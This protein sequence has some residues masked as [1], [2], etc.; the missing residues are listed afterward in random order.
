[1]LDE[2]KKAV[3][4]AIVDDYVETAEP[5]GSKSLVNKHGFTWSSATI[6]NE[7]AELEHMGYLESPHTSA[8]R[9]PSDMGYRA[10][11]DE[12]LEIEELEKAEQD[13]V[14]T[15]L[16]EDIDEIP[17][18]IRKAAVVLAGQ[19]Q[20]ASLVLAPRYGSS[21][22]QQIRILMIEPGCALVI[23]VLSA[24][25][26]KDRVVRI[27]SILRPEQLDLIARSIETH[28]AG[29]KI[30]DITMITLLTAVDDTPIPESLLNQVVYETYVSIK[31]AD[32]L[33][34]YM[35]GSHQLLNQPE[36]SDVRK[37]HDFL[38]VLNRDGMVAVIWMRSKNL[39]RRMSRWAWRVVIGPSTVYDS[40]RAE[41]TLARP[42]GLQFRDDDVS[43]SRNSCRQN[44]RYWSQ[45][46]ELRSYCFTN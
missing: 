35:Q 41:I 9:I 36:F 15:E 26:V 32:H 7:M 19:T 24:G 45:A 18:L 25:I 38:E 11:V 23:V 13:A 44:R 20:L 43:S 6:R 31:Q 5:V 28:L 8:S 37:A 40:H 34:I 4:R 22:L 33:D 21:S 10:Y 42:R 2:R 1:M 30:D 3:L 29:M 16:S 14:R 46:Y 39:S 27:P 12:L 17:D